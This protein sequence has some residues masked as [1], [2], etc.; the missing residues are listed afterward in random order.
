MTREGF[1][2]EYRDV[3]E[4]RNYFLSRVHVDGG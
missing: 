4:V 3:H 1:S 2:H